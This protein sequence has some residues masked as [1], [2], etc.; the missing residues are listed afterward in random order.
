MA[1]P[2]VAVAV[3]AE[4]EASD[5]RVRDDAGK[6][7]RVRPWLILTGLVIAAI[8]ALWLLANGLPS[9]SPGIFLVGTPIVVVGAGCGA[10]FVQR[11]NKRVRGDR[12]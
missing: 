2:P 1:A 10:L 6:G 5:A 9:M 7:R 4:A 8:V 3:A 12:P 11:R